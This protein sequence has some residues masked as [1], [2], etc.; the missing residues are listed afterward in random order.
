MGLV[1]EGLEENLSRALDTAEGL[2][3]KRH[4]PA[5]VV[6][7]EL[8]VTGAFRQSSAL[9][10]LTRSTTEVRGSSGVDDGDID[11]SEVVRKVELKVRA[12]TGEAEV[13]GLQETW[14][15]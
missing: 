2:E 10:R 11:E 1:A 14:N 13:R 12:V 4:K 8:V 5:L 3:D 7:S 6:S 9:S 15:P